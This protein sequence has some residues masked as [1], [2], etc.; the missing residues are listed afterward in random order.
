MVTARDAHHEWHEDEGRYGDP[1]DGRPTG[2]RDA[3]GLELVRSAGLAFELVVPESF[4][5]AQAIADHLR[6]GR[7]VLIDFHGCDPRLAGRLMD[8][9]SGL[10][11]ALEGT[12]QH[13][14]ADVVLLSP[15][16]VDLSGDEASAVRSPG[17][18]NRI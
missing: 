3:R 11:Y 4:G 8:F 1:Y 16:A 15:D 14:G 13:V 17:F 12:L 7:P 5:V 6:E 18:H 9:A 10:V 2:S